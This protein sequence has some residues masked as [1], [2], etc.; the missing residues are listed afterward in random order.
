MQN[1]PPVEQS[2]QQ[3]SHHELAIDIIAGDDH[4]PNN[5]L[6]PFPYHQVL[7]TQATWPMW[8][9][10]TAN[11]TYVFV[12]EADR[13]DELIKLQPSYVD[14][15]H[16]LQEITDHKWLVT[17]AFQTWE[18]YVNIKFSEVDNSH[19]QIP[20]F[21]FRHLDS[22]IKDNMI[23]TGYAYYPQ[24]GFLEEVT[25]WSKGMGFNVEY[26]ASGSQANKMGTAIHEVGHVGLGLR[27]PFDA[28]KDAHPSHHL[29]SFS[30]MNYKKEVK[31]GFT[32]V[33]IS[34]M[35][36][37]IEAAQQQYGVNLNSNTGN[38]VYHLE[39]LLTVPMV[40][41]HKAIVSLPWDVSGS[42]T[43]CVAEI[44]GSVTINLRP[45]SRSEIPQGYVM[46]PNMAIEHVIGA[47]GDNTII[48]NKHDNVV[49]ITASN[50]QNTIIVD[51]NDCG[52]DVVF[53][54]RTDRDKLVFNR[55]Q[56]ESVS[57][58][59]T[60][61][62]E[63][64]CVQIGDETKCYHGG[65]RVQFKNG[66]NVLLAEAGF[67]EAKQA[68]FNEVD[69]EAVIRENQEDL[70]VEFQHYPSEFVADFTTA[71][72]SG[73]GF[74]FLTSLS[75][76]GMRA[77]GCTESQINRVGY[78]MNALLA[79]YSGTVVSSSAALLTGYVA[80]AL[81]FSNQAANIAATVASTSVRAVQNMSV[82]G[83]ARTATSFIGSYVG[84]RFTLWARDEVKSAWNERCDALRKEQPKDPAYMV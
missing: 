55:Y 23:T 48:L 5:S 60:P 19:A 21:G 45:F 20:V 53:G 61:V 35:P 39:E 64:D 30:I 7:N 29:C 27:H 78:V 70:N 81:G 67:E 58:Q 73:A 52:S 36:F 37:D 51:P 25:R 10:K 9:G 47:K 79:L 56:E 18:S 24:G 43:I 3:E 14:R 34:P 1:R 75:E 40:T 76:D 6:T 69:V 31:D 28:M 16:G 12:S 44:D 54:Y 17:N 26:L 32:L 49:D 71:V 77:M 80:R 50:G 46:M 11:V 8:L 15:A 65:A 72:A 63:S 59:V 2:E 84:C 13:F 68:N 41:N 33:P 83:V 38:D 4:Y 62:I 74:T 66:H 57:Y 22:S 42:D 82:F